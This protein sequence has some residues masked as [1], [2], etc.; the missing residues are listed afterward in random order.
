MHTMK[1]ENAVEHAVQFLSNDYHFSSPGAVAEAQEIATKLK[2][3]G[4]EQ[5]WVLLNSKRA[6][7]KA[8]VNSADAMYKY[9][10]LPAMADAIKAYPQQFIVIDPETKHNPFSFAV[11]FV[12]RYTAAL[13]MDQE[14]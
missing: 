12:D 11:T 5:S 13:K 10:T 14:P 7:L 1:A 2:R 6:V 3:H 4:Q 9:L 8:A